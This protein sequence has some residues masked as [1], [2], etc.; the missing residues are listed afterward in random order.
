[1]D[2]NE[3]D[4]SG[5]MSSQSRWNTR[6]SICKSRSAQIPSDPGLGW[7]E[8]CGKSMNVRSRM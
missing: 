3:V 8:R 1:M 6:G 2:N 4:V 5:L 7:I